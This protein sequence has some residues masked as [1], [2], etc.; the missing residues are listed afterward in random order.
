MKNRQTVAKIAMSLA[1][2]GAAG[3]NLQAS[4][5]GDTILG[6]LRFIDTPTT[7]AFTGN[8]DPAIA[9]VANGS[10]EFYYA[11]AFSEIVVNFEET[12]G[13]LDLF[14]TQTPLEPF[15]EDLTTP[16]ALQLFSLD[17][18]NRP[19]RIVD[20]VTQEDTFP[21]GVSTPAGIDVL[22]DDSAI[23]LGFEGDV[24]FPDDPFGSGKTGFSAVYSIAVEHVPDAGSAATLMLLGLV[25]IAPFARRR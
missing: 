6:D 25:G 21:A 22:F 12:G 9:V 23:L 18:I 7:N 2:I 24:P 3:Q 17:W 14:V 13:Q 20:V 11:D 8:P 15:S 16:W 1:M 4:L 10:N 19:G 5:T